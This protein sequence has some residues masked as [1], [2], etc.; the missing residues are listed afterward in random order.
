VPKVLI[1]G[2]GFVGLAT[3][4]LFARHGWE[5]TGCTHSEESAAKLAGEL[6]KVIACDIGE[7]AAVEAH[8]GLGS[9]DAVVHCAS[10]GRGGAEQY[11]RVYLEGSRN[12]NAV[13]APAPLLFTSSTSVYAQTDGGW[14]TEESAAEPDRETGRL[15]RETEDLVI[16]HSGIVARLAGIYGPGRSVLLR[17]FFDGTAMIEGDGAKWI[18]QVHRDDIAL[19]LVQLITTGARGIFN[20]NDDCPLSQREVYTWLAQRFDRPLPPSGPVDTNRK[21][22][23]TNKRVSNARLRALGWVPRFPS[24]FEAVATDPELVQKAGEA[25]R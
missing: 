10:S 7:R 6:F 5:V 19:A 1:A 21:R 14:V 18:N 15:L 16:A 13:F 23:W 4:R 17:K 12:L 20:V 2:C 8:A 22:G 11:G 24:F 25:A 9:F 3:A